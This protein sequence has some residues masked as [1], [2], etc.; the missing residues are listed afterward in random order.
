MDASDEPL[1]GENEFYDLVTEL[2][3]KAS[4]VA[5]RLNLSNEDL[6]RL[7]QRWVEI[8]K[9]HD[10]RAPFDAYVVA[11]AAHRAKLKRRLGQLVAMMNPGEE[12]VPLTELRDRFIR[13]RS[14]S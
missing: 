2:E 1:P 6:D 9:S 5:D 10:N 12:M 11:H 4:E 3:A 7:F 14:D 8:A 13:K